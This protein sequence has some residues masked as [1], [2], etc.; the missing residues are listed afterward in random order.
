VLSLTNRKESERNQWGLWAQQL[1]RW[2]LSGFVASLLESAGAFAP[3]AAQSIYVG[4][5]LLETWVSRPGLKALAEL[6]EDSNEIKAFATYL[7]EE[8]L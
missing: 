5:P 6:L 2:K 1:H 4:Q 8:S 7:R 3:M